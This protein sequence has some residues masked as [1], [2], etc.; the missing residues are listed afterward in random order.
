MIPPEKEY[1]DKLHAL[2][3]GQC[4][5]VH[6]NGHVDGARVNGKERVLTNREGYHYDQPQHFAD[7]TVRQAWPNAKQAKHY[8]ERPA[9]QSFR[10]HVLRLFHIR[11]FRRFV[12]GIFG[13]AIISYRSLSYVDM[14]ITDQCARLDVLP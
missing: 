8:L 1:F 3:R 4:D 2:R 10:L 9:D 12:R 11:V 5:R 14:L 6:Q 13:N 7:Q